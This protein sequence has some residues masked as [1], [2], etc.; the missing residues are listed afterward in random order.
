[1]RMKD[2]VGRRK[3]RVRVNLY[4]PVRKLESGA[5]LYPIK[6]SHVLSSVNLLFIPLLTVSPIM[7]IWTV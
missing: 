7:S 3:A 1:M 2:G 5:E 4:L 6:N